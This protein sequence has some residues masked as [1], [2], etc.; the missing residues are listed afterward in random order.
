LTTASVSIEDYISAIYHLQNADSELLPLGLLQDFFGFSPISI[1][2]MVQKLVQRGLVD[3][4]PY[5]GVK[6]TS[7]GK[8]AAEAL[9]R[10][11]R[12]WECFLANKLQ[13]PL[14]E[15]HL[16]A[17]DL[18]H[19]V[20][21]WVTERLFIH[22]GE[23]GFCPHGSKIGGSKQMTSEICLKDVEIG[24]HLMIT[25]IQQE[26]ESV[27]IETSNLG[28]LPGKKIQVILK[29]FQKMKVK[30]ENQEMQLTG[31]PLSCIWGVEISDEQ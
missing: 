24:H 25:R 20:P 26:K 5:H 28:L 11:H 2:E 14:D 30:A 12:I 29:E 4:Q 22:L 6:L 21:D 16:L 17:G 8:E 18:E 9:V 15:A 1:H 27:L 23:P 10:R 13:V 7:I 31:E 3:Y 19:V